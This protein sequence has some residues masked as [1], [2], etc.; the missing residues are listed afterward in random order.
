VKKIR[1]LAALAGAAA[2]V[3]LGAA[4]P[5]AADTPEVFNGLASGQALVVNLFGQTP[6][7]TFGLTK[8]AA[9]STLTASAD[10][11]GQL[12]LGPT[13]THSAVTGDGQSAS[14]PETCASALIPLPSAITAIVNPLIACS[15]TSAAVVNGVPTSTGTARV[16][17]LDVGLNTLLNG[18]L[19]PVVDPV[20]GLLGKIT[21][22]LPAN[23]NQTLTDLTSSVQQTQT[24][25]VIAGGT[26]SSVATAATTTTSKAS[27]VGAV[28]NLLPAPLGLLGGAPL[29]KI[30][31]G[32]SA[33]SA[34]YD[35]ASGKST[36][37]FTPALVT[38]DF[39]KA[40]G[41]PSQTVTIGQTITILQGTPLESTIVAANGSNTTRPDGS[42]DATA[43][44]VS[45][46]LLKGL[47]APLA[48]GI[49]L[50]LSSAEAAAG[51]ALAT[52]TP[53]APHVPEVARSLP[54]TGGNPLIPLAGVAVLTA[55]VVLRRAA[56]AR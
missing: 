39:N 1:T 40:L 14:Q 26:T 15:G 41:I 47:P 44:A 16:A 18:A 42:V 23:V 43:D 17:E 25:Q 9:A 31:V 19:K 52:K 46:Q 28:I 2:L 13:A 51:G 24:L 8:A 36:S 22:N 53:L 35:R 5:A 32:P 49:N 7:L 50:T 33:A 12:A 38:I 20:L 30:T 34:I 48:G 4:G 3:T 6:Q 54:H 45:L 27:S 10:A 55:A 56:R 37:Q 29:V 21:Q 11:A